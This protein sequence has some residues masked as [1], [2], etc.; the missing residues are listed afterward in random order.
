MARYK[1]HS[2]L[3]YYVSLAVK[4]GYCKTNAYDDYRLRK[5]KSLKEPVF[6]EEDEIGMIKNLAVGRKAFPCTGFVYIP[7][8]HRP[9]LR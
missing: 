9:V 2:I 4:L 7:M 8:L 5:G 6:L 1:I 3:K